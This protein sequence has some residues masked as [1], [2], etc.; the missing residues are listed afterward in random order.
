VTK[1]S[2]IVTGPLISIIPGCSCTT[3]SAGAINT[4]TAANSSNGA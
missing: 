3:G 2:I 4:T 1:R